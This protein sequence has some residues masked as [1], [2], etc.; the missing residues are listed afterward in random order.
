MRTSRRGQAMAIAYFHPQVSGC[1]ALLGEG[2]PSRVVACNIALQGLFC[3]LL[4]K[5]SPEEL[6]A[7][8]ASLAQHFTVGP[9]KASGVTCLYFVKEGQR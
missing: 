2:V 7:L 3:C 6:A 8:K 1:M 9:G 4:Q 5:L